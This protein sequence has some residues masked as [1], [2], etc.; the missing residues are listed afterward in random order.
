MKGC[1]MQSTAKSFKRFRT[2]LTLS[3]LL[4]PLIGFTATVIA[5]TPGTF[6]PTGNMSAPRYGHTATLLTNG[7]VLITGGGRDVNPDVNPFV[8]VPTSSAELYDSATGTFTATADMTSGRIGHTATLLMDGRILVTGGLYN[9]YSAEL[10][11]PSVLIPAQVVTNLQF[12][13][14]S[15]VAGSSFSAEF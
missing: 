7:K 11:V 3:L 6:R 1:D 5:Q 4:W 12:D 9:S 13:R 15:V 10:Y 14:A 8:P 2:E